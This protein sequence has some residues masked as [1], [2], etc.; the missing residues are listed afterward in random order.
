VSSRH[1]GRGQVEQ[2]H[3]VRVGLADQVPAGQLRLDQVLPRE[4]PVHRGVDLVGGRLG[5]A[6]VHPERGVRPPRQGGQLRARA[7]HPGHDQR[8][9]QIPVWPGRAQ[10][11]RQTHRPGLRQHRGHVSVRQGPQHRGRGVGGDERL[12]PKRGPQQLH[13]LIRQHRQVG[14]RLVLDLALRTVGA[15]QQMRLIHPLPTGLVHMPLLD[16]GYMHSSGRSAH[17]RTIDIFTVIPV[18]TRRS[19]LATVL[20]RREPPSLIS[21]GKAVQ[22]TT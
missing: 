11:R 13:L 19:F 17:G 1:P 14:Q 5:H 22:S 21:Q 16:R 12:T 6:Q 3:P 18:A 9:R 7:D 8:Q 10:Q 4:Q 20:G 15:P 2:G